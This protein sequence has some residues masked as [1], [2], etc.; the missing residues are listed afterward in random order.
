[1]R[2]QCDSAFRHLPP[3]ALDVPDNPIL[4]IPKR[5][6]GWRACVIAVFVPAAPQWIPVQLF[7]GAATPGLPEI[8][9]VELRCNPLFDADSGAD[10]RGRL[11]RT[12][13][14]TAMK[15]VRTIPKH[16]RGEPARLLAPLLSQANVNV[17][18]R[19]KPTH[20]VMRRVPDKQE[21]GCHWGRPRVWPVSPQMKRITS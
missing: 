3:D 18:T 10:R 2:D 5:L 17:A 13:P 11:P 21:S 19:E 16:P 9:L 14:G 1:M 15:G 4:H 20:I 8:N 7:E 6:A 12:T